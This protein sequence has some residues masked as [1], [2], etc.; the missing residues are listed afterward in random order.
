MNKNILDINTEVMVL[1]LNQKISNDRLADGDLF[2][3]F[4]NE[5]DFH[6][7]YHDSASTYQEV[8][9]RHA[10]FFWTGTWI[11]EFC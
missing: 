3:I 1:S 8:N 6:A 4:F 11:Y 9:E 5:F 10:D 7:W 2:H